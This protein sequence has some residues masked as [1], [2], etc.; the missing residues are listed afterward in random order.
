[1]SWA[2]AVA[3]IES[4]YFGDRFLGIWR[5]QRGPGPYSFFIQHPKGMIEVWARDGKLYGKLP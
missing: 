3:W 1:M 5:A 4:L 2:V